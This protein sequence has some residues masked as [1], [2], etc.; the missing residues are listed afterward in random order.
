MLALTMT[1]LTGWRSVS[2]TL[3]GRGARVRRTAIVVIAI[4]AATGSAMVTDRFAA[5]GQA[6]SW[7]TRS[8]GMP[9]CGEHFIR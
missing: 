7:L 3:D 6:L 4:G 5:A 2:R 9:I 8:D 1:L